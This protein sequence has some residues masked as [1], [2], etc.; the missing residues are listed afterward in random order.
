[1]LL[2]YYDLRE[3]PFGVTPDP[4]Y[5]YASSTHREALASILYGIDSGLGFIALTAQPGMGK[6]TLLFEV[7]QRIEAKAKTVFLFQTISNAED[8]SRAILM[9]LGVTD[10]AATHIE[11][12]AQLNEALVA[13]SATGKR[14]VLA[15][16]E[17]QRLDE[18]VLE[19]V[20]V[21]SNFETSRQKLVQIVLSGQPELAEKLAL[22]QL[23]QLRQR[24]SIFGRLDPLSQS[25]TTE[26]INHRLQ[27][28]G[29][30]AT[31][32][33]FTK[34]ALALICRYSEGIP[35]N[36]NNICFNALSLGYAVQSK[37]IDSALIREV[38]A[39][40]NLD[41]A[42]GAVSVRK[43]MSGSDDRPLASHQPVTKGLYVQPKY[44]ALFAISLAVVV[45]ALVSLL[46][47]SESP[48]RMF[49]HHG[50]SSEITTP[51][52]SSDSTS[53][54]ASGVE[55]KPTATVSA[56][57]SDSTSTAS[58]SEAK[59]LAPV[60]QSQ[61]KVVVV[62]KG[63]SLGK[64]CAETLGGCNRAALQEILRINP[65]IHDANHIQ[66]GQRISIPVSIPA[67]TVGK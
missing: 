39:D 20:R 37:S 44:A 55:A 3:Q 8:L 42:E 41:T 33:I 53:T 47:M 9:D 6:T 5:L 26:Y 45:V 12:Q 49:P 31:E 66:S 59:P 11:R 7:L 32:P 34:S 30:N 65:S 46:K 29:R 22:P 64:L 35:R 67:S 1:M 58:G 13:H 14:L 62:R 40:L 24:I 57:S 36:I 10:I 52:K 60:S 16:D 15:I 54:A 27:I 23:L 50:H 48:L 56:K 61:I 19:A 2:R 51:A 21:L 28:A 17:A 38:A 25:E 4:R 18:P 63:E 43:A